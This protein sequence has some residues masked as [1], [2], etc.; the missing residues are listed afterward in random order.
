MHRQG[1]GEDALW[2][3]REGVYCGYDVRSAGCEFVLGIKAMP[4]LPDH[5]HTLKDQIAQVERLTGETVA[6][7]YVDKGYRGHGL[8]APEIH[9]T[10]SPG[11]R[12]PNGQ[13]GSCAEGRMNRRTLGRSTPRRSAPQAQEFPPTPG[14]PPALA[15]EHGQE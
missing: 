11:Q 3:R 6:R 8:K 12:S 1:K 14:A 9:I 2:I 5:G 13:T 10:Q 15:P 7:V 4:G